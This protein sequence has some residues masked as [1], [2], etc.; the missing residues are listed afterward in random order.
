[1]EP[2]RSVS[3]LLAGRKNR[4]EEFNS[5]SGRFPPCGRPPYAGSNPCQP[6]APAGPSVWHG[7]QGNPAPP[8]PTPAQQP[9]SQRQEPKPPEQ[10]QA[11]RAC[12]ESMG[13]ADRVPN[14]G[15]LGDPHSLPLS[16]PIPDGDPPSGDEACEPRPRGPRFPHPEELRPPKSLVDSTPRPR[17]VPGRRS[18][19]RPRLFSGCSTAILASCTDAIRRPERAHRRTRWGRLRLIGLNA[20]G[21]SPQPVWGRV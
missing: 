4:A 14:L 1:M 18:L 8:E 10:G 12:W 16:G 2:L 17:I 3:P 11:L 9:N 13:R 5:R 20:D 7:L 21:G 19:S 6:P 15:R